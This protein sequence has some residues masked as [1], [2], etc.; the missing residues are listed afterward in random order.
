MRLGS[1]PVQTPP[2]ESRGASSA[3]GANRLRRTWTR[4]PNVNLP[5]SPGDV[6]SGSLCLNAQP[7]GAGAYFFVNETR[8]QTRSFPVTTGLPPA[9]FILAG[10]GRAGDFQQLPLPA[11]AQFGVVYFDEISAY[12]T[13][14]PQALTSGDAVTMTDQTAALSP[15]PKG[16]TTGHSRW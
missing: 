1:L 3:A 6:I 12:T 4:R 2:G 9:T 5:G 14:G 15:L 11:L 16:S 10:V 13:S 8:G 7:P